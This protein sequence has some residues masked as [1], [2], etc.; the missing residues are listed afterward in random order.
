MS[1]DV[2]VVRIR[3]S[4]GRGEGSI[5]S[6][7]TFFLHPM[8]VE[9]KKGL[10]CDRWYFHPVFFVRLLWSI[11]TIVVTAVIILYLTSLYDS[12]FPSIVTPQPA[13][14]FFSAFAIFVVMFTV[15]FLIYTG[16]FAQCK[17]PLLAGIVL[18]TIAFISLCIAFRV[19]YGHKE[20][21]D[22]FYNKIV[23]Y[24]SDPSHQGES[25]Y[26]WFLAHIISISQSELENQEEILRYCKTRTLDAGNALIATAGVWTFFDVMFVG[27][28][29]YGDDYT[30][31]RT[32][33]S[34]IY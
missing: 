30:K 13:W 12:F 7:D 18:A 14:I 1:L 16:F 24:I 23:A 21:R 34:V 27:L 31:L 3:L 4:H 26:K 32:V 8:N 33:Q 15:T 19:V 25:E 2:L 5:P 29:F 17:K 10:L 11:F 9:W 6:R 20:R 22:E 28:L